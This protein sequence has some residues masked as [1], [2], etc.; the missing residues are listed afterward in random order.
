M[1][2]GIAFFCRG[3]AVMDKIQA[4]V[5]LKSPADHALIQF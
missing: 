4:T 3:V 2:S 5:L 1:S